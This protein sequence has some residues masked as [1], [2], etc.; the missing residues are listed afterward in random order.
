MQ[1]KLQK[2]MDVGTGNPIVARMSLGIFEIINFANLSKDK[3]GRLKANCYE[4]TKLLVLAEKTAKPIIEEINGIV[5]DIKRTGIKTQSNGRCINL[6]SATTIDN[7]RSFI[8]YAKQ[9]LQRVAENIN[10]IFDRNYQGPHFHKIRDD[11]IK[12]F[13]TDFIV[14]KLL[15]DDQSWI[16]KI[17]DLRNEDEHPNTGKPYCKN[18][19]VNQDINKKFVVTLPTFFEGTQIAN[20][21]EVYSHNLLTFAEEITVH[22]LERFFPDIVAIYE[23]PEDKRDSSVPKRFR[24]GLKEKPRA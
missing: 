5:G 20:A 2:D 12:E 11:F 10:I 21:L 13:G 22:S 18:F 4:I 3:K 23:I 15:I 8:K 16:K 19:D 24:I 1:W 6:P 7:S 14:T 9:V 17:I